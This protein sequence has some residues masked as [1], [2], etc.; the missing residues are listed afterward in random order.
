MLS[1]KDFSSFNIFWI[2]K[3]IYFDK[4]TSVNLYYKINSSFI[5]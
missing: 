3:N 5:S 2:V 1:Q 4:L